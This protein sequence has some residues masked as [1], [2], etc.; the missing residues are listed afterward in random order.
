MLEKE[1]SSIAISRNILLAI[2]SVLVF[3]SLPTGPSVA[4]EQASYRR[5]SV[6]KGTFHFPRPPKEITKWSGPT[7][8][9]DAD[10]QKLIFVGSEPGITRINKLLASE[11][12]EKCNPKIQLSRSSYE[13][14]YT[15]RGF[16]GVTGH[17]NVE[18][19]GAGGSCHGTYLAHLF[20]RTTGQELRLRDVVASNILPAVYQHL[21]EQAVQDRIRAGQSPQSRVS[22]VVERL[23]NSQGELGLIIKNRILY[24]LFNDF[25]SSCADGNRNVVSLPLT[26]I[27]NKKLMAELGLLTS[28]A[29][30]STA[31]DRPSLSAP[32]TFTGLRENYSG[33]FMNTTY[34]VGG[35]V[36]LRF[37]DEN[38][39]EYPGISTLQTGLAH[40]RSVVRV[41][42]ME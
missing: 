6:Q 27:Q 29:S 17:V 2:S 35:D 21:A 25:I 38:G 32:A 19:Q 16:I 7:I 10:I 33:T 31:A 36:I 3:T 40:S 1:N 4:A 23:N 13:V 9:C 18:G 20:D 28:D 37:D 11:V 8:T 26:L 41:S 5:V 42:S 12:P 15:S 34:N 30:A 39:G 24:V 14:P 22:R